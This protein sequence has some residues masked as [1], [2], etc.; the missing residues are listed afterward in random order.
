MNRRI[1]GHACWLVVVISA[2]FLGTLGWKNRP[3]GNAED[4]SI[5]LGEWLTV[6]PGDRGERRKFGGSALDNSEVPEESALARVMGLRNR[7]ISDDKIE[8]FAREAFSDPNPV[9][10]RLAF[11]R[12]LES[13]TLDNAKSIRE[14]L[15][16]GRAGRD[17]WR[18]FHYAW[19]AIAGFEALENGMNT[20]ETDMAHTLTG[21]ASGAPAEAI[22]WF[23][24]PENEKYRRTDFKQSLVGGLADSDLGLATNFVYELAQGGDK[25]ASE[26]LGIVASEYIRSQGPG[27]SALWIVGIV[28]LALRRNRR[29]VA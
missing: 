24:S 11:T 28:L 8:E 15:K 27:A 2:Y 14:H 4:G 26:L 6:K 18:D 5:S 25:Q 21:W 17:E 9:R 20:P 13:L 12:L 29:A 7:P 19:G 1:I 23:N 22:A 3:S 16:N 10:R